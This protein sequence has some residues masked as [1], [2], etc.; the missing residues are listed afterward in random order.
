MTPQNYRDLNQGVLHLWSKFGDSSW[1][2]NWPKVNSDPTEKH[3]E[4]RQNS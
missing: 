1:P 3:V 4:I 2:K